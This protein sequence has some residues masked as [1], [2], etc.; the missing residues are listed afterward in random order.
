MVAEA[1]MERREGAEFD[2]N[3]PLL[4]K[5][6]D[7]PGVCG[8]ERCAMLDCENKCYGCTQLVSPQL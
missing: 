1:S 8:L 5:V 7:Q 4:E 2:F 6:F 3:D